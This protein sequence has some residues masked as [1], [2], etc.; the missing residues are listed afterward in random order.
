MPNQFHN[1]KELMKLIKM[2]PR[3]IANDLVSVQP[4]STSTP[5]KI[6]FASMIDKN[7]QKKRI[8]RTDQLISIAKIIFLFRT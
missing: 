4:L 6:F 5:A 7:K 1:N 8:Q 2:Y 3:E